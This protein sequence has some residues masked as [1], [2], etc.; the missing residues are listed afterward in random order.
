MTVCSRYISSCESATYGALSALPTSQP[1]SMYRLGDHP[2]RAL[3][4]CW[5]E[6]P[7]VYKL[8]TVVY[9]LTR[10]TSVGK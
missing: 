3:A 8:E 9:T 4:Q 7:S 2:N 5:G 6:M 1:S 10:T